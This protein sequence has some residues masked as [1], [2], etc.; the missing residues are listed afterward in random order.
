MQPSASMKQSVT[1]ATFSSKFRSKR[2][3]YVFLTVDVRAYL[4]NYDNLTVYFCKD[5]VT[6]KRKLYVHSLSSH[7]PVVSS[8]T[9]SSIS[10]VRSMRT[11]PSTT[12]SP[13]PRRTPASTTTCLKTVICRASLGNG[14][15]MS[16][17]LCSENLSKAGCRTKSKFAMKNWPRSR[18]S[19]LRWTR[20][21]P[22]LST[23]ASTSAVSH[24]LLPSL[25]CT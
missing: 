19:T 4:P 24:C 17:T 6:G 25:H 14:Y 7:P 13:Q 22:K 2:E 3:I 11:S 21:L 5:L 23:P 16:P 20:R 18:S 12:S 1:S 8:A 10:T 9:T 15:S